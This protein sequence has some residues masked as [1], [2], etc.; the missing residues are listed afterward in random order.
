MSHPYEQLADLLDGTLDADARAR[1]DAHL[2]TCGACRGDLAAAA[3]GREA[4]RRLPTVEPPS[5]LRDRTLA[6]AG[7]GAAGSASGAPRWY[8]WAGVAAAALLIGVIAVSLPDIGDEQAATNQLSAPAGTG[9]AA[10]DAAG[11]VE[12]S[13]QNY[14]ESDLVGLAEQAASEATALSAPEQAAE[15]APAATCV[16]NAFREQPSGTLVQLIRARFEDMPAYL[17]IYLEGPGA[18]EDPD[19]AV[20]WVASAETCSVLSFAQARI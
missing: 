17:A 4:A 11:R 16:R 5:D 20:V 15:V 9:G 3:A 13:E 18:G 10:S 1:V 2:A 12:V 8:R 14:H 7:G 19:T 6:A